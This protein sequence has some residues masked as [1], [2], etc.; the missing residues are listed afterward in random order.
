MHTRV[1]CVDDDD[2]VCA[3]IARFLR[4]HGIEV[5]SAANGQQAY[6][7]AI[8]ERPA[9]IITDLGMP[10][11]DGEFLIQQLKHDHRTK[12]TPVIVLTGHAATQVAPRLRALGVAEV[13]TKPAPLLELLRALRIHLHLRKGKR[14]N[15]LS[16]AAL[17]SW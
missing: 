11:A 1:L 7:L 2:R 15:R 17:Q 4:G 9:A 5:I 8:A 10:R 12:R 13:L 6:L 16:P 14:A 3:G